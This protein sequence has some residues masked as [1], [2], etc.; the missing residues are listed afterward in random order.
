M[1][2]K[3]RLFIL[4]QIFYSY[5]FIEDEKFLV[6]SDEEM[7]EHYSKLTDDEKNKT[8]R[9]LA[10]DPVLDFFTYYN[11]Y[12][13]WYMYS[14]SHCSNGAVGMRA[15]MTS[16]KYIL[17]PFYG[18]GL[19]Q[20]QMIF[21]TTTRAY[22]DVG[23]AW[24]GYADYTI[25][26]QQ[27]G[28]YRCSMYNLMNGNT[29]IHFSNNA[30]NDDFR[31]YVFAYNYNAQS[32]THILDN[33]YAKRIPSPPNSYYQGRTMDKQIGMCKDGVSLSDG[34]YAFLCTYRYL[35]NSDNS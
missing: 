34:N 7:H 22:T 17:S 28:N 32:L 15:W 30:D 10:A 26:Y 13:Q 29:V 1:Y 12:W 14:N 31:M 35:Q 23:S 18:T 3:L 20:R 4:F 16:D 11:S 8:C 19:L 33:N 24:G 5:L 6:F 9:N 21:D 27:D 2:P 25:G